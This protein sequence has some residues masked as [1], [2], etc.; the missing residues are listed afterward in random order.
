M[1]SGTTQAV[2]SQV[3][4]APAQAPGLAPADTGPAPIEVVNAMVAYDG[5]PVLR[6][7]SFTAPKGKLVGIVGPN[8][9]G[10][11]TLLKAILGLV[12]LDSGTVRVFGL[13]LKNIRRRVAYVPQ[14]EAVDWD[15]PVTAMDVVLMGSYAGLGLFGRPGVKQRTEAQVAL[16]QVGMTDFADRHIRRLSGGQQQRVFLARALC[17]QADILLLDEPFAGVDAATEQAIFDLMDRLT[18][19]GK[20]LIVVNHD[21]SVLDRFD[22]LMLLNQQIVAFGP[23][24][25]VATDE[26]LRLTYGG[27]LSLLERADT[28]LQHAGPEMQ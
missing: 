18:A 10:K 20:T 3:V 25:H 2:A 7:V 22:L 26:N 16:E 27:R 11:S 19:E 13:P 28:T 23:T 24:E 14:T 4:G 15:F 21:L 5:R 9:A 1:S 12:R 6:S 8:G 17:Q